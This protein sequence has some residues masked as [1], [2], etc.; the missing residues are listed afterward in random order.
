M[1]LI[2]CGP[3]NT[4]PDILDP[5]TVPRQGMR[6]GAT[7]KVTG[8][9]PLEQRREEFKRLGS[10]YQGRPP[11]GVFTP[12]EIHKIY[13][14][15]KYEVYEWGIVLVYES[16]LGQMQM[17]LKRYGKEIFHSANVPY[18]FCID[19]ITDNLGKR[20]KKGWHMVEIRC[21]QDGLGKDY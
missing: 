21:T 1:I 19:Y 7:D 9:A 3:K 14:F 8:L 13:G 18:A 15:T 10:A 2:G 17:K 12:E 6:V 5:I 4:K 11:L 20:N 16:D